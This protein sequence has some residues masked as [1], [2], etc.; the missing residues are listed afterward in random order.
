MLY[1]AASVDG[2]LMNRHMSS[3]AEKQ[4]QFFETAS[5]WD[6]YLK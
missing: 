5:A 6:Y 1:E 3:A 4:T 2:G